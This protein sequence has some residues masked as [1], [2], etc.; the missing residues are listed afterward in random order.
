M[1]K[2]IALFIVACNLFATQIINNP[3]SSTM[4]LKLS[5]FAVNRIV[6]PAKIINLA[7]SQE[8]GVQI[9]TDSNQVFIKWTPKQKITYKEE[10]SSLQNS[11]QK[12]PVKQEIVYKDFIALD[13]FVVTEN[14][15]YSFNL[16]PKNIPQQ[17]VIINDFFQSKKEIIKYET[18]NSYISTLSKITKDILLKSTVTGYEIKN[19]NKVVSKKSYMEVKLVKEHKGLMYSAYEFNV[20]NKSNVRRNIDVK[21]YFSYV[22]EKPIAISVYYN[23]EFNELLPFSQAKVIYLYKNNGE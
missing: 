3:N 12:V 6:L 15:T 9:I 20:S 13:L 11:R 1:K 16:I 21:D 8:K 23:N 17:T 18:E 5:S 10:G 4:N 22:K 14:G 7:Y 19:I 2:F